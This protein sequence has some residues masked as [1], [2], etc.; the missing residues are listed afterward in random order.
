M[1]SS[2]TTVFVAAFAT[3]T[4]PNI[5]IVIEETTT[6]LILA[7]VSLCAQK[8]RN[9]SLNPELACRFMPNNMNRFCYPCI[10]FSGIYGFYYLFNSARMSGKTSR[11]LLKMPCI[12]AI[13]VP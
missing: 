11:L 6:M 4:D 5:I 1:D 13:A 9:H 2:G 8:C 12:W 10:T 3:T 7:C